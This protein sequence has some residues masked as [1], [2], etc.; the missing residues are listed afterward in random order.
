LQAKLNKELV[1]IGF[2]RAMKERWLEVEKEK[3]PEGA[4][5]EKKEAKKGEKGAKGPPKPQLVKRKVP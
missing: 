4:P 5:E 1:T 2:N 3:K